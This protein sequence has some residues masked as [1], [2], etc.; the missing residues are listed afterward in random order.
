MASGGACAAATGAGTVH[1]GDITADETWTAAGAPHIVES[2]VRIL[3]NV[4]IEAC[5]D[6]VL[7]ER[8]GFQVGSAP[9]AGS[10]VTKGQRFVMQ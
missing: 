3:A 9:T 8:G 4:V 10:L 2:N 5:A 7:N 6:V 1:S